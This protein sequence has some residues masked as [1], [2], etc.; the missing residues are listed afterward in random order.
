MQTPLLSNSV[1]KNLRVVFIISSLILIVS[2]TSAVFSIKKLV[3]G[4]ELVNHTNEVLIAAENLISSVKDAETDQRGF[5]LTKET[6]FL[7]TYDQSKEKTNKTLRTLA[8]LTIDNEVQ[9]R[10]IQD[11]KVLAEKRFAHLEKVILISKDSQTKF[12]DVASSINSEIIHGK[13][14]MDNLFLNS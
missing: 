14:I 6:E 1:I 11:A 13:N 5:L 7:S 3:E 12:T 8:E 9:Q 2:I 10:N 4:S